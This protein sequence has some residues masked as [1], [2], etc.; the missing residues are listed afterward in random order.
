MLAAENPTAKQSGSQTVAQKW[1]DT[2]VYLPL[3]QL[4]AIMSRDKSGV[5]LSRSEYDALKKQAKQGTGDLSLPKSNALIYAADYQTTIVDRQLLIKATIS[6]RQFRQRLTII[7]L[8]LSGL[9]VESAQLNQQP[10]MIARSASKTQ[11]LQL[12]SQKSGEHQLVLQLSA[13]LNTVG[14]DQVSQF[15]LLP[16]V[17]S[18]FKIELPEKQHL[19][20]NELKVK[21][22]DA[23]G[24][25]VSYE[26][27]IGGNGQVVLK[28]TEQ[29]REQTNDSLIFARSGIGVS[30]S[31]GKVAWQAQTTLNIFGQTLDQLVLSV[32]QDLEIISVESTG[33]ESWVLNDSMKDRRRTEITLNYRQPV[34]GERQIVCRGVMTTETEE[35]W[36]V[37]NLLIEKVNSHVGSVLLRYPPGVRLQVEKTNNVRRK[38]MDVS[39][40]EKRTTSDPGLDF[41]FWE[42]KFEISLVTQ[43]K[44][45]EVQMAASTVVDLNEQGMDLR[46]VTTV[47]SL[48]APLFEF[49][50]KIPAEWTILSASLQNQE[51]DWKE[52]SREAGSKLVRLTFPQPLSANQEANVIVTAHRDLEN[53]PPESESQL[54]NIPQVELPQAKI[55]EGSLIINA[56]SDWD[57]VPSELVN[58]E[59]LQ[60]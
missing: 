4:D 45:S 46:L 38:A 3:D 59:P 29:S 26:F 30:V 40:R 15:Q 19:I 60:E 1:P 54:L 44:R 23:A 10:A 13:P 22:L 7:D 12:F 49:Q 2:A 55:L 28:L 25:A 50:V 35:A 56:D 20:V 53:W 52:S 24:K 58:L 18:Q 27:P 37:P 14:S 6:I 43:E 11:M 42:Q 41:D 8:P 16:G 17:A 34:E 36:Q 51:I 5:L 33:L 32:P 9:A 21:P 57:L 39:S 31:P 48:F 47:E